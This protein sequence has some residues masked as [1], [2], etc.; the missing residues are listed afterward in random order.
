MRVAV[1]VVP[2]GGDVDRLLGG[3]EVDQGHTL[4]PRGRGGRVE[5]GERAPHVAGGQP[6]QMIFG[7][8]RK[9][10]RAGEAAFVLQGAPHQVTDR[11][12]VQGL[13]G[14]QDAPRQQR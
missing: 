12:V 13:Q 2:D 4:R 5:G 7:V 6:Y 11:G 3:G 1:A 8:R 10:D 9:G 14:E